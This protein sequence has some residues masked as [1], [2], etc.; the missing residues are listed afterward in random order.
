MDTLIIL[1]PLLLGYL[2]K[3]TNPK[4]LQL[5]DRSLTALIYLILAIMGMGLAGLDNLGQEIGTIASIVAVLV[6]LTLVANLALLP[7]LDRL[8]PLQITARRGDSNTLAM[9]AES[10]QLALVVLAGFVLGLLIK[11]PHSWLDQLAMAILMLLLLL[12]GIQMRAANMTLR[13]I[14]LNPRGLAIAAVVLLTSL[15]AGAATAWGFELPLHHG[16]ALASGVGWYSLSGAMIS[17]ELGPMMGSIAFLTDLA[18]ELVAIILIPMLMPRSPASAIG[19]GGAT[20]MDFT[21]PVIQRSGGAA[22]V[23]VAIVSGFLLSLAGPI[24]IPLFLSWG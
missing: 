7:L 24:L 14:V 19:Y 5:I 17:Q 16:L 9:A 8:L 1:S 6:G 3:L 2:F 22:T 4:G 11:V 13:Q 23:P 20:A 10:L 15:A 21:L 12:I 18:R